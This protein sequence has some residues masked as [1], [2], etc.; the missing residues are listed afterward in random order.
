MDYNELQSKLDAIAAEG[1]CPPIP[2]WR[3]T[4]IKN[5]SG[6]FVAEARRLSNPD[7]FRKPSNAVEESLNEL[8]KR[9]GLGELRSKD[10]AAEENHF[11]KEKQKRSGTTA[12]EVS[13]AQSAKQKSA[14]EDEGDY[15]EYLPSPDDNAWLWACQLAV[16]VDTNTPEGAPWYRGLMD[17]IGKFPRST[18]A[19]DLDGE[20]IAKFVRL[21]CE[22]AHA[23]EKG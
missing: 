15:G 2:N 13:A 23:T 3:S 12:E 14:V 11:S 7:W 21:I 6:G 20:A 1:T 22:P 9:A 5:W 16:E 19:G 8:L 10:G 17:Y 18:K 4:E